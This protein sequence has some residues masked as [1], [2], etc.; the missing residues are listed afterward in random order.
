MCVRAGVSSPGGKSTAAWDLMANMSLPVD[1]HAHA[2][3]RPLGNIWS[4]YMSLTSDSTEGETGCSISIN[5]RMFFAN[6]GKFTHIYLEY[7][8]H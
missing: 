1:L 7:N 2:T 3:S 8:F 5:H 6:K 4:R